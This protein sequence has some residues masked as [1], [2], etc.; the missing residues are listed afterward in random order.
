MKIWCQNAGAV[1]SAAGPQL[2]AQGWPSTTGR[3]EGIHPRG[4]WGTGRSPLSQTVPPASVSRLPAGP[5]CR[6][7]LRGPAH[8]LDGEVVDEVV[9]VLVEAAVQRNAVAVEEQVLQ[10]AHPLQAQCPLRAVRQVGV[11]EQH[12]EAEGLGPQRHCLPHATWRDD[13][14]VTTMAAPRLSLLSGWMMLPCSMAQPRVTVPG[15]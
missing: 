4:S 5:M 8:L 11:V 2:P 1:A 14:H 3:E 12:A 7:G 9:V 10:G 13:T 6:P 15:S